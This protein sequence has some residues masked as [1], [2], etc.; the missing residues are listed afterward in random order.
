MYLRRLVILCGRR[1]WPEMGVNIWAAGGAFDGG[2]CQRGTGGVM[3]AKAVLRLYKPTMAKSRE[4]EH[5][6]A[7]CGHAHRLEHAWHL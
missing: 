2:S 5:D 4:S 7:P 1:Q 6:F 3:L